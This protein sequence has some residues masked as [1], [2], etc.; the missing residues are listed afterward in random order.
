MST[1]DL[2]ELPIPLNRED[3]AL[4]L[5]HH[6]AATLEK[7]VGVPEASGFINVVGQRIGEAILRSY[8]EE[9]GISQLDPDQLPGILVDLKRRIHGDFYV[10]D[11]SAD[12][13]TLGNRR[14][15]FGSRALGHPSMCM[16]TSNVFGLI[17]A[18]TVGHAKVEIL[19]SIARGDAGCRVVVHLKPSETGEPGGGRT[20]FRGV[21]F[22]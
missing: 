2:A 22:S 11:A 4:D 16:M 9:L 5:I 14:C 13:I 15:P 7:V 8:L 17:S 20:Y 18:E 6:L 19:E 12:K 21:S 3:F 1:K 10:I